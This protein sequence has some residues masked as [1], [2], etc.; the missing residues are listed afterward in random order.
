MDVRAGSPEQPLLAIEGVAVYTAT[1]FCAQAPTCLIESH[2]LEVTAPKRRL[3][4]PLV[5]LALI[6]L[7]L[8]NG[9]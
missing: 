1:P 2:V 6:S 3:E 9:L 4:M 8:V 7:R 5:R